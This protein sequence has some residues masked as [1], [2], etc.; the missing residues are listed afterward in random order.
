ME[1]NPQNPASLPLSSPRRGDGLSRRRNRLH[2]DMSRSVPI[3]DDDGAA[4][5]SSSSD[6]EEAVMLELD[7]EQVI[8]PCLPPTSLPFFA[9]V[10]SSNV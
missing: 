8:R 10:R 4:S 1:G 6:D 2:R 3:D 7:E 9:V 5:S